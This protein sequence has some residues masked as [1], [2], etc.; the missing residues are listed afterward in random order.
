MASALCFHPPGRIALLSRHLHGVTRPAQRSVLFFSMGVL[1]S[2]SPTGP[3][4]CR[5]SSGQWGGR[6]H[7]AQPPHLQDSPSVVRP[8][9][10]ADSRLTRWEHL[11]FC[12]RGVPHDRPPLV[13]WGGAPGVPRQRL[14]PPPRPLK[15][16]PLHL[17]GPV[18]GAS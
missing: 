18:M 12:V 15:V 13:S 4:P 11:P 8:G 9:G 1:P 14:G 17:G 3:T 5:C 7:V 2:A 16:S 6:A 10:A